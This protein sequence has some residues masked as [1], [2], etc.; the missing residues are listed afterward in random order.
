MIYILISTILFGFLDALWKPI[1]HQHGHVQTL[2]HRTVLTTLLIGLC[3]FVSSEIILDYGMIAWTV[4]SGLLAFMGLFY[5]TKAFQTSGTSII[6]F[7]NIVT[8]LISQFTALILFEENIDQA[9][10][11]AQLGGSCLAI[12]AL[13]NFSIK[14]DKGIKY[15]LIASLCFGVAYPIMGIPIP[16]I[17][18]LQASFIQ[19]LTVLVMIFIL[20][21][22]HGDLH[23]NRSIFSD[24]K[25][26]LLA[27]LTCISLLLYFYAYTL[28]PIYK[29]NLIANFYPVSALA[30]AYFLFKEKI[31]PTQYLGI[32]IAILV[33]LSL[34]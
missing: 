29:V 5:L 34:Y 12:I 4:L 9:V 22:K 25:I 17:G 1:I 26:L 8:V 33:L 6:V 20:A 30:I 3:F 27:G 16:V 13:N 2:L 23:F 32:F 14:L 24:Q 28:L 10:Y 15:G 21:F 19:E 7:L 11:L 31:R 18:N